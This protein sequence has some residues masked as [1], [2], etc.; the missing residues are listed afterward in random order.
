MALGSVLWVTFPFDENHPVFATEWYS[1]L[2]P[3]HNIPSSK[4]FFYVFLQ[5]EEKTWCGWKDGW[6][7]ELLEDETRET[8]D[9]KLIH[10]AGV[11]S[12]QCKSEVSISAPYSL[13]LSLPW[14]YSYC[15]KIC[16]AEVGEGMFI[17]DNHFKVHPGEILIARCYHMC[18]L[19]VS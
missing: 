2:L 13:S 15:F 18:A 12:D 17:V 8:D 1:H 7:G 9:D 10:W 3:A 16:I 19:L 14:K 11:L 4:A 5:Y 6:R